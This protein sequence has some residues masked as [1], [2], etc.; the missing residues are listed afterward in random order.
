MATHYAVAI[1]VAFACGFFFYQMTNDI[2]GF[3]LVS[4]AYPVLLL[5]TAVQKSTRIVPLYSQPF[6][7]FNPQLLRYFCQ[8]THSLHA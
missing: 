6:R 3:Q 1:V 8:R 5:M 4:T 2:P 7:I